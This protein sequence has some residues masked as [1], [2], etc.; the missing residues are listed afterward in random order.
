[1][2]GFQR[3]IKLKPPN[4]HDQGKKIPVQ[5]MKKKIKDWLPEWFE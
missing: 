3:S 5:F 2:F 1:M 4:V